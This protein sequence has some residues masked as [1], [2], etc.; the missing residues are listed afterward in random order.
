MIVNVC[1]S[2]W[3]YIFLCT[4]TYMSECVYVCVC[5]VNPENFVNFCV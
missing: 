3:V 2:G 5:T 1:V 4:H